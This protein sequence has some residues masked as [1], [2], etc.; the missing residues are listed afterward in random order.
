MYNSLPLHEYLSERTI[1][2][3]QSK[4][5]PF[6]FL[7]AFTWAIL[8]SKKELAKL[9]WEKGSHPIATA[10]FATKLLKEMAKLSQEDH[11]ILDTTEGLLELAE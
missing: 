2:M 5:L 9:L 3:D 6:P 1:S 4:P 8:S 11:Q 10:L 7:D